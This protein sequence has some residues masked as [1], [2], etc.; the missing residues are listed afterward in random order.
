MKTF[1]WLALVLGAA[2]LMGCSSDPCGS[3]GSLKANCCDWSFY[4]PCD[5]I[6]GKQ[7]CCDVDLCAQSTVVRQEVIEIREAPA[8]SE[9]PAEAPAEAPDAADA[10]IADFGPP[11]GR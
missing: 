7:A 3:C 5:L 9:A 6:E 1:T 11:A 4:K 8:P 10:P 2:L